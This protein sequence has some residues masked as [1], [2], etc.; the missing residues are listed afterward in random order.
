[1]IFPSSDNPSLQD[2]MTNV[3]VGDQHIE[4]ISSSAQTRAT[5]ILLNNCS[6]AEVIITAHIGLIMEL[7]DA[8]FEI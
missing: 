7:I 1:M 3:I 4:E 2:S 8:D 6:G 5:L